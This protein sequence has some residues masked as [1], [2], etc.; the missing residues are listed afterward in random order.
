MFESFVHPWAMAAGVV[1]ISSPIIIHLINRMRFR[2]VRWAAMEFL[3]RAQKRTRRKLIIE[4]LILLLLRILLVLLTGLLMARFIGCDDAAGESA[5]THL[6]LL[7][8]SP[9]TA[10]AHRED[11]RPSTAFERAKEA[12]VKEIAAPAVRARGAQALEVV[13]LCEPERTIRFDRVNDATPAALEE[14]LKGVNPSMRHVNLLDGLQRM[15]SALESLPGRKMLHVVS[16]LRSHDFTAPEAE[17]IQ[18]AIKSL[19]DG[20][21]P[22]HLLDISDPLRKDPRGVPSAHDNLGIVDLQPESRAAARGM[23][24]EFTVTLANFGTSERKNVRVNVRVNDEPR[25]REDSSFTVPVLPGNTRTSTHTFVV[26]SFDRTGNRERPLDRF[27]LVSVSLEDEDTGLSLDNRRYTVV[28]VREKVPLLVI[29]GDSSRRGTSDADSFYLNALFK[30]SIRGYDVILDTPRRLEQAGLEPFAAIYL[31]DVPRLS[32]QAVKNLEDYTR[33]GGGLAFFLGEQTKPDFYNRWYA[34]G[35]GLFPIPLGDRPTDAPSA[36]DKQAR[37]FDIQQLKVFPRDESHPIL[38]RIYGEDKRREASVYLKFVSMDRHFPVRPGWRPVG[39]AE[40]VLTLPNDRSLDDY[41]TESQRLLAQLPG[42]DDAK[43]APLVRPFRTAVT[44]E[45]ATGRR[46]YRLAELFDRFLNPPTGE[47]NEAQLPLREYWQRPE[48]A[49]LRGQFESFLRAVR[50]GDPLLVTKPYGRGRTAVYTTTAGTTWNDFPNFL[51]RPYYVMLMLELQKY[52]GGTAGERNLTIGQAVDFQTDSL[53]F[54][55]RIRRW[56]LSDPQPRPGQAAA[57]EPVDLGEQ[58]AAE[59]KDGEQSFRF[60]GTDQPGV[61]LFELPSLNDDPK[62]GP[63]SE[64]LV[65]P[66][67]FDT[68]AEGDLRRMGSDELRDALPGAR[69]FSPGGGLA[70]AIDARGGDWSESAWIYLAFLLVLLAEQAMAVRLSF[71]LRDGE[72]TA[73]PAALTR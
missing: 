41:K 69:V 24:V 9:S 37:A 35:N 46:L 21:V 22:V 53:R 18:S 52:L 49:E 55:P 1:L 23:P 68:L 54:G 73:P 67:N 44:E 64:F 8:D 71:H 40:E 3:L 42:D 58:A 51:A 2:R 33:S 60:E 45:L 63:R 16:D 6:V 39:G 66:V 36:E 72:A 20:R 7:D 62:T 32:D 59:V 4:Q 34:D 10:D 15:R 12:L 29:E 47:G 50:Y 27:N 38:R 65:Q 56:L 61:Y 17:G 5:T 14:A 19:T 57:S 25:P 48:S 11:G 28:D 30:D 43:L 13:R 26:T 31:L 70:R